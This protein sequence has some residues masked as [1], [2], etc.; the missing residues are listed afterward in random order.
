V[1]SVFRP[2]TIILKVSVYL[3]HPEVELGARSAGKG[4]RA[5]RH[6]RDRDSSYR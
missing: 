2:Q 6:F 1:M 4:P 3:R 5:S